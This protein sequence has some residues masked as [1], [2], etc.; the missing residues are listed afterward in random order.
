[1]KI[2]KLLPLRRL[3]KNTSKSDQEN[4][5]S[6]T[7]S[8]RTG[9]SEKFGFQTSNAGFQNTNFTPKDDGPNIHLAVSRIQPN[10]SSQSNTPESKKLQ[11]QPTIF[12][13]LSDNE[14]DSFED[15]DALQRKST[16]KLETTEQPSLS[17]ID[18]TTTIAKGELT[19]SPL[20]CELSTYT[21]SSIMPD[22]ALNIGYSPPNLLQRESDLIS[23][24]GNLS[25]KN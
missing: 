3:S 14:T 5:S 20:S 18:F 12:I 11:A 19:A 7:P 17:T 24:Q 6:I 10:T 1:M 22:T 15:R 8:P 25:S 13:S 9:D 16:L 2:L 23:G 4:A 21:D